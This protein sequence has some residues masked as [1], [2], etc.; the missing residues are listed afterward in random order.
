MIDLLIDE[1]NNRISSNLTYYKA[2]FGLAELIT[3]DSKE[4]PAIYTKNEF[5]KVTDFD[6]QL[7][8][9]WYRLNGDISVS[10]VEDEAIDYLIEK[11]YP[12]R[13]VSVIKKSIIKDCKE[14]YID[15][16]IADNIQKAITGSYNQ[17]AMANR[18][19][20]VYVNVNNISI[21]RNRILTTEIKSDTLKSC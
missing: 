19:E 21:N 16:F 13:L 3:L 8:T 7:G 4:F 17:F 20:L 12:I 10:Q 1:L 15:T 5:V 6:K 11:S 18:I 2:L 14:N 9:I